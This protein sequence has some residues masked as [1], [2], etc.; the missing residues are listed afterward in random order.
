MCCQFVLELAFVSA[1]SLFTSKTYPSELAYQLEWG[2]QIGTDGHDYSNGVAVDPLGNL[3]F[4]M[5]VT[6]SFAGDHGGCYDN[7]VGKYDQDGNLMWAHQ[8]GIDT[9]ESGSGIA[10][11]NCGNAYVAGGLSET[12]TGDP[13]EPGMYGY[14]A[15]F[16]SAG[17]V[18]WESRLGAIPDDI[19]TDGLGNVYVVGDTKDSLGAPNAG[20]NDV[21]LS[22]F[23]D[24]GN[25]EW[26]VQIGTEVTESGVGV[27]ADKLGNVFITGTTFGTIGD[28]S[29]GS[30]DP[31]AIKF[32]AYGNQVWAK[33]WGSQF[34]EQGFVTQADGLGGAYFGGYEFFANSEGEPVGMAAFVRRLD[35]EG[36]LLWT[37]YLQRTTQDMAHSISVD[38]L[39]YI[40]VGGSHLAISKFSATGI[41]IGTLQHGIDAATAASELTI[42]SENSIYVSGLVGGTMM[43]PPLGDTDVF[44]FKLTPTEVPEPATAV[45]LTLGVLVGC[46]ARPHRPSVGHR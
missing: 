32:D 3:F 10:A 35:S 28:E 2:H 8:Y 22:K 36:N 31:Y 42:D 45:L 12:L 23:D 33:Q 16:S 38:S 40:Y 4:V 25:Q 14:V 18:L 24:E 15:K 13:I 7:V 26:I 1:L 44:F 6:G 34:Y 39:G 30:A 11:D 29:L 21:F 46:H 20:K 17:D 19:A 43:G 9:C 27:S 37:Q 5:T 41:H